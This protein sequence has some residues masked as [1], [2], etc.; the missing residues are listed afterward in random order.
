MKAHPE[1]V[2]PQ[3]ADLAIATGKE[4]NALFSEYIRYHYK[5]TGKLVPGCDARDFYAYLDKTNPTP[6]AWRGT[7]G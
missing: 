1:Y 7:K 3:I 5:C 6:P 4:R 2:I